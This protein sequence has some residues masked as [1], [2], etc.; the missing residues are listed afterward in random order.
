[1]KIIK[2]IIFS[3]IFILT[4]SSCKKDKLDGD[5]EILIGTWTSISTVMNCGTIP[6]QPMNP[7][8][9]L[10]L[11]EKGKYK[12]YRGTKKIEEGRLQIKINSITFIEDNLETFQLTKNNSKLNGRQILN[13]S[14]GDTINIDRN[15][16][17]DDYVYRFIKN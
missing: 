14:R 15:G 5:Q 1:M 13:F 8:Y 3:T 16:C 17:N 2:H 12:L 4:I 6:G 7:N 10:E 11:I 9:K